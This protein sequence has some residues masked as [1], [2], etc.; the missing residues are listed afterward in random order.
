[1]PRP[2][3]SQN[4]IDQFREQIKAAGYQIVC[5]EGVTSLTLRGLAKRLNCSYAKPYRY[6]DGKEELLDAVRAYAYDQF[7]VYITDAG[8]R[9]GI[10]L[11]DRY[12][13]FALD[14]PE[15]FRLI[16]EFQ[17]E[18]CSEETRAAQL[19]AWNASTRSFYHAAERGLLKGEPETVAHIFWISYHGLASLAL[20]NKFNLGIDVEEL[21]STLSRHLVDTHFIAGSV[22]ERQAA[23]Q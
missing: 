4:K 17:P 7:A 18:I 22:Q 8:D 11:N 3:L 19:R 13:R 12:L 14:Y 20:A 5:E 1:M 9:A 2:A 10:P 16:Y 6:F 23:W 15:A 21:A